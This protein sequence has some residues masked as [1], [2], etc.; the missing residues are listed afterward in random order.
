MPPSVNAL[1]RNVPQKGRVKTKAYSAW[2]A[3]AGLLV[4][5]QKPERCDGDVSVECVF[6]PRNRRRDIDNCLKPVL[7]LIQRCGVI[8]ND[9]NVVKVSAEWGDVDGARVRVRAV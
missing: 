1:Y 6:G 8:E 9:K 5:R 3:H 4:N 7:D 2:I